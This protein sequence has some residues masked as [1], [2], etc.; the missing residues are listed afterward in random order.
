L[1]AS[2]SI[3]DSTF[4]IATELASWQRI[5]QL[6]KNSEEYLSAVKQSGEQMKGIVR[7]IREIEDRLASGNYKSDIA[8]RSPRGV[9]CESGE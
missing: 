7:R 9:D 2:K 8:S 1:W 6:Q 5:A 3:I 4:D